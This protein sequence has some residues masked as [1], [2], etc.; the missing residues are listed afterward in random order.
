M[1]RKKGGGCLLTATKWGLV[2]RLGR[3][4]GDAIVLHK[5]G[6]VIGPLFYPQEIPCDHLGLKEGGDSRI[7]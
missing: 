3:S 1:E 2:P 6:P 7:G 5:G 4:P